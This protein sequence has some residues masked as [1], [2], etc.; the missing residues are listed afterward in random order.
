MKGIIKEIYN[1]D[2]KL[3][4]LLVVVIFI[5]SNVI[6]IK[7][8]P[9]NPRRI[10]FEV[11]L[12]YAL[13]VSNG[14]PV[15]LRPYRGRALKIKASDVIS[16]I[17][18]MSKRELD[19]KIAEF[20]EKI[21]F[22]E[23]P[24]RNSQTSAIRVVNGSQS[25]RSGIDEQPPELKNIYRRETRIRR[26]SNTTASQDEDPNPP[27]QVAD[28]RAPASSFLNCD[29]EYEK[30]MD[31]V[32]KCYEDAD[33]DEDLP[34]YRCH[35]MRRRCSR[36]KEMCA[37]NQAGRSMARSRTGIRDNEALK[38]YNNS[39]R[40]AWES[41]GRHHRNNYYAG[42]YKKVEGDRMGDYERQSIDLTQ[43]TNV[44]GQDDAINTASA[45]TDYSN[46]SAD[47][48][49]SKHR[50]S[51]IMIITGLAMIAAGYAPDPDNV[52]LIH[53]GVALVIA[54]IMLMMLAISR[55]AGQGNTAGD[56]SERAGAIYEDGL[57]EGYD[58]GSYVSYRLRRRDYAA[59]N[60]SRTSYRRYER[61]DVRNKQ[62]IYRRSNVSGLGSA[63]NSISS[64]R[65]GRSVRGST[66]RNS[67]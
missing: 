63:V 55:G 67:R 9:D 1:S 7:I 12:A 57:D 53:A 36:S 50:T 52:A 37:R 19:N 46:D 29:E 10:Q 47:E 5:F 48:S 15:A 40:N 41:D 66:V 16:S 62:D 27:N 32:E 56:W 18:R 44:D 38:R 8:S 26:I 49:S 39:R 14:L 61:G 33:E 54:G 17:K 60:Y 22:D 34:V 28:S 25:R 64:S 13:A 24:G 45:Y 31:E 59:R 6:N 20:E 30:C 35:I 58:S 43:Q 11:N 51:I 65:R 42:N 21:D 4:A 3:T 2:K 23:V